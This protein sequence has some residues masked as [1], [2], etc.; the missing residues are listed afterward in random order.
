MLLRTSLADVISVAALSQT[1]LATLFPP[2]PA[3]A[4]LAPDLNLLGD[5]ARMREG[6]VGER[7]DVPTG[8]VVFVGIRLGFAVLTAL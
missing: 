8:A 3:G 1:L 6:S 7:V 5:G 4:G 2:F